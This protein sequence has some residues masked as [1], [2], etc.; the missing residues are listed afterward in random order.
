MEL[1]AI[2]EAVALGG[3]VAISLWAKFSPAL[4]RS[5]DEDKAHAARLATLE[6]KIQLIEL[7]ESANA[8]AA[9]EA[10][11]RDEWEAL[12]QTIERGLA[13]IRRAQL[14]GPKR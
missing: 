11:R 14:K 6:E 13:D 8:A 12:T 4:K 1:Q 7:R 10:V 2:G 3:A 5:E 9:Q